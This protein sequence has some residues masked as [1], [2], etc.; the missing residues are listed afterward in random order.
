MRRLGWCKDPRSGPDD[1][2]GHCYPL[3]CTVVG[4]Y[5]VKS[6]S[7]RAWVHDPLDAH[8]CTMCRGS[9][10]TTPPRRL[11]AEVLFRTETETERVGH[12]E[13]K[14]TVHGQKPH[15]ANSGPSKTRF[16]INRDTT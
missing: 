9:T 15:R 1:L 6:T 14:C 3:A 5:L 12:M 11:L 4:R 10:S 7:P 13:A 8:W 2:G 16:G